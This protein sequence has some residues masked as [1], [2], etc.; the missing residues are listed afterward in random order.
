MLL[1]STARPELQPQSESQDIEPQ[2]QSAG[3]VD[4]AGDVELDATGATGEPAN[5]VE[6]M[7]L[8]EAMK[9]GEAGGPT[10]RNVWTDPYDGLPMPDVFPGGPSDTRVL[11]SYPHH[12]VRYIYDLHV[13]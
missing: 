12:V 5:V 8:E 11:T 13:S 4:P 7:E 3:D 2:P 9:E 6:E 1:Q 10:R